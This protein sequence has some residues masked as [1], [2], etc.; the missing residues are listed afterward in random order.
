MLPGNGD[1]DM[2][3]FSVSLMLFKVEVRS[4]DLVDLAMVVLASD[5]GYSVGIIQHQFATEN[6]RLIVL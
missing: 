6:L 2:V 1:V 4:D 5:V 3:G